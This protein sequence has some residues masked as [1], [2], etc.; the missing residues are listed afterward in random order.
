MA[1]TKTS[2]GRDPGLQ[3]RMML[4]LFL[5]GAL[6]VVFAGALFAAGANGVMILLICG[7]LAAVS[8][9]SRRTSSRCTRWARA[10]SRR[11]RRRSC[12]R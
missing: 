8:A 4:T 1:A 5:L 9:A 12:T 11:R 3:F 7:G 6:Y 10:R 2:F